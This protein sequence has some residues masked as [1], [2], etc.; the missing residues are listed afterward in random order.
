M[1][2][3]LASLCNAGKRYYDI[4]YNNDSN[5]I[6]DKRSGKEMAQ[7]VIDNL[8]LVVTDNDNGEEVVAQE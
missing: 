3:C 6:D 2:D 5:M 4:I 8:G 1:T 7:E